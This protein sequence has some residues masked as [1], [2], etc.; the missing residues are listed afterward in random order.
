MAELTVSSIANPS[1]TLSGTAKNLLDDLVALNTKTS[2][3]MARG[4]REGYLDPEG[5]VK[6]AEELGVEPPR[7]RR[8]FRVYFTSTQ[9]FYFTVEAY[10]KDQALREGQ[11]LLANNAV[12]G[13]VSLGSRTRTTGPV[14][15]RHIISNAYGERPTARQL[16]DGLSN[17]NPLQQE[18]VRLAEAGTDSLTARRRVERTVPTRS[19]VDTEE[20]ERRARL[21]AERQGPVGVPAPEVQLY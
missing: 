17:V 14:E 13:E 4:I 16:M 1:K 11:R 15:H 7:V 6:V 18:V 8:N 19:I 3:E 12:N 9:I 21:A 5:A 10:D 2:D 20:A